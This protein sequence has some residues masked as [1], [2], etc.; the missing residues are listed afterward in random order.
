MASFG[1]TVD[2]S[3]LFEVDGR[4]GYDSSRFPSQRLASS[5]SPYQFHSFND[6]DDDDDD[7]VVVKEDGAGNGTNGPILPPPLQM[8]PEEEEGFA[9]T[10]WRR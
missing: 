1:E 6:D 8:Q 5:S 9:L 3:V 7:S 10:E 4:G 2:E